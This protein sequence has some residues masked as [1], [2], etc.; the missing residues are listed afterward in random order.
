MVED[1][2][3]KTDLLKSQPLIFVGVPVE[4]V[5]RF[6]GNKP[7]NNIQVIGSSIGRKVTL[8][9]GDFVY[10]RKQVRSSYGG[11]D[12]PNVRYQF[13]FVTSEP[14]ILKRG[15]AQIALEYV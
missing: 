14:S 4:E 6:I 7:I 15:S 9:P 3:N 1:K 2:K 12:D 5:V 13:K 11:V 10:I 8:N